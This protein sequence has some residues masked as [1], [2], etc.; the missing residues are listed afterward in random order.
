MSSLSHRPSYMGLKILIDTRA[1]GR[2]CFFWG[3]GDFRCKNIRNCLHHLSLFSLLHMCWCHL[4]SW[5]LWEQRL[6]S[7]YIETRATCRLCLGSGNLGA[8]VYRIV[9][10]IYSLLFYVGMSYTRLYLTFLTYWTI[11]FQSPPEKWRK[12]VYT[13]DVHTVSCPQNSNI[14]CTL[15]NFI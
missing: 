10:T 14:Y 1:T 2:L 4:R 12:N 5:Y 7:L 15:Y 6:K 8:N 11:K 13:N 9:Y 3:G